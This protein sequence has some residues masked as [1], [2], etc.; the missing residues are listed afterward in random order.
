MDLL[1]SF[2]GTDVSPPDTKVAAYVE[3][4]KQRNYAAAVPLLKTAVAQ[5]DARAMG[6]FG[7]LYALGRGVEKDP[8]DA[9]AWFR[10]AAT[11]GNVQSQAAL[12]MCL[13]GG[14]G[15][16]VNRREAAYWLYQ[17]G[18]AGNLQAIEVLGNLAMKDPS[19]VGEHFSEDDLCNLA[20]RLMKRPRLVR[21]AP[22]GS[23]VH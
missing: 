17:A 10:Q 18:S 7:A 23:T 4:L 9:C 8:F 16:P 14:L 13:A 19:I 12:G 1:D 3:P 21:A 15:A 11:R 20:L 5:E 2:F 22:A 6:L